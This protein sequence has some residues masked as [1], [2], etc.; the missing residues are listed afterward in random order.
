M[1]APDLPQL[2]SAWLDGRITEDESAALQEMLRTSPEAR[3]EFRR[4]AQLDAALREEP[5]RTAEKIIPLPARAVRFRALGWLAAA[6]SF[7]ALLGI[8]GL[9]QHERKHVSAPL[10]ATQSPEQTNVGCAVLTRATD[11]EFADAAALRVGDT[12]R[13]GA[14]R[15]TRGAAQIEFFSG[16]SMILQA[17]A[18]LELVS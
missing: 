9:W 13:P 17:G 8:T 14:L 18:S 15:L 1:S 12:I 3:A 11:A 2:I 7:V 6:A 16:A 5:M 4:W 10:A